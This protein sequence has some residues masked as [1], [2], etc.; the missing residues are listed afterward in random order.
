[1]I[2]PTRFVARVCRD[3][4]VE[5][6]IV[7]IPE[8]ID[9]D[10]YPYVER[11][12]R[13]GLTTLVVATFVER[14]NTRVAVAA[15]KRAFDGDPTA[16]L[17]VKARFGYG[18][19]VPDDPRIQLVDDSEPTR[20][21]AHWY[22][23]ADV[24]LALGSEGF[25]LPLVEG[26]ATGL[27]AI[28][29]DSEG[30]SDT[31]ADAAGLLLP[32]EPATWRDYEDTTFGR[33]GVHGCPSVEDV[34]DRLRWVADHR[35]EARALGRAAAEWV[36]REPQRLD[37][38]PGRARGDGGA[39]HAETAAAAA[40]DDVGSEPRHAV[41]ARRAHRPARG[42]ARDGRMLGRAAGPAARPRAARPA[43]GEPLRRRGARAA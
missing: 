23:R 6:P 8:G 41:R 1:M 26:M 36:P 35:D 29:L 16:R 2:V 27:P 32:V 25:G 30:Q 33:C 37:E 3:S 22:E 7:V 21:I 15:W 40:A 43:P 19:F 13:E 10:V 34:A 24:L 39:R 12:E 31:C 9:P 4:G 14:K 17:I 11:P 42:A 18:N 5:V 20:G 38:G 28:A